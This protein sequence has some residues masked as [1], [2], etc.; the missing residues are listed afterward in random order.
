MWYELVFFTHISSTWMMCGALWFAKIDYYALLAFVG[1]SSFKKYERKHIKRTMPWA[2]FLLS[3]ELVT[4]LLLLIVP[5]YVSPHKVWLGLFLLT[6]G[7][8]LT[9]SG[10]VPLSRTLG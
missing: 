5:S 4:G 3:V 9:W 7:W 8:Y 2:V 1:K 6:I 10:C